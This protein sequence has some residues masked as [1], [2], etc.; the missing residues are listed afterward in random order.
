M[1]KRINP[2]IAVSLVLI[3]WIIQK[4]IFDVILYEA[5]FLD[6]ANGKLQD[7]ELAEKLYPKYIIHNLVHAL[8]LISIVLGTYFGTL[9]IE[10]LKKSYAILYLVPLTVIVFGF[11][12]ASIDKATFPDFILRFEYLLPQFPE[13]SKF[14]YLVY[15]NGME[16]FCLQVISISGALIVELFRR[17]DNILTG[18]KQL[19]FRFWLST[20]SFFILL[21]VLLPILIFDVGI[22]LITQRLLATLAWSTLFSFQSGLYTVL[23]GKLKGQQA[24][25]YN[26]MIRTSLIYFGLLLLLALA[27]GT[28]Y[29]K[30]P[31]G[32]DFVYQFTVNFFVFASVSLSII[33]CWSYVLHRFDPLNLKA[34][35]EL[36]NLKSELNF[37][38]SQINPHFLFN[39]LNTVYGLA[40][41]DKSPR[42]ADG[43]QKLSEMMRFMLNENTQERIPL[44]KEIKYIEDYV[45]FQKLRID[46]LDKIKVQLQINAN[47]EG[48]IAP[49]LLIP[50]IENAFKHGVSLDK[51]S[52]ITIEISCRDHAVMLDIKNSNHNK[53]KLRTDESGVGLENVRQRLAILYPENHLFQIIDHPDVF[54]A[55]V[56]VQLS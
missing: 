22:S 25:L 7:W 3:I 48:N 29:S 55:K 52:W 54:E 2:A 12:A 37:L 33:F 43:I 45:E 28:L 53:T 10:R 16:I 42:T 44:S 39:S 35:I 56:K 8:L 36:K 26:R 20:I 17:D 34:E 50:M 5:D 19:P 38:K 41:L 9:K 1:L 24:Q 14:R 11:L 31:F 13:V 23:L 30:I 51:E 21:M 15:T 18:I 40:L 32:G 27:S 6:R 47:C 49:M 4:Y 46:D